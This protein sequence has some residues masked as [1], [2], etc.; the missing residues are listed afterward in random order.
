MKKLLIIAL[1]SLAAGLPATAQQYTKADSLK[2]VALLSDAR[3]QENENWMVF[4]ARKL[5]DIPYVAKTLEKNKQ[6]QLIVNLRQLD[7]TTYVENVL[8]L[9]L[10]MKNKQ[11]SFESFCKYLRLIRYRQGHISYPARLHY[12]S[13][14]IDDNTKMGYVEEINTPK[15][16]FSAEQ[17]LAIN[18]MTTHVGQYPML[19]G[20]TQ[21]IEI[22]RKAEEE[23]TGRRVPYIPKTSIGNSEPYWDAIHDGDIIA[24]CTKKAG[25]DTSHIGIAVWHVDGL[26]LLNASQIHKRTIEEPMTM[27]EYM[28]K[29]PSQTG[30]RIIR[31]K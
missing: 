24:I 21:W 17:E 12:F 8:A 18:Y 5:T 13:S 1:L 4:F 19:I 29:H 10:C 31:V 22:I 3:I 7:C 14:W 11:Y 16:V 20:K 23:L 26:H 27:G 28:K 30:I 6:E 25:L 9:T 2:V 15:E